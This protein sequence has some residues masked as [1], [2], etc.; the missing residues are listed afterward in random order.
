MELTDYLIEVAEF[1]KKNGAETSMEEFV[2]KNGEYFDSGIIPAAKYKPRNTRK[3]ECFRNA[4]YLATDNQLIYCEGFAINDSIPCN[5]AWCVDPKTNKVVDPTWKEL[6]CVYY[7]IKFD[8]EYVG[9]TL[10]KRKVWGL[11]ENPDLVFGRD[12]DFQFKV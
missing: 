2:L 1:R 9:K 5:H 11:I 7:G 3:K 12:K 6:D 8:M 4:Y 10:A